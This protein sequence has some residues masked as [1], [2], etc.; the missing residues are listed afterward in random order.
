MKHSDIYF[1]FMA[2]NVPVSAVYHHIK[3]IYMHTCAMSRHVYVAMQGIVFICKLPLESVL[4]LHLLHW[5]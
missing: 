4:P 1:L 2:A 5:L 3:Y